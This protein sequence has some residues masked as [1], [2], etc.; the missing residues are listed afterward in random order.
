MN[1]VMN[2]VKPEFPLVITQ[3]EFNRLGKTNKNG[4]IHIVSAISRDT[5]IHNIK[6]EK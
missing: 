6:T 4:L 1:T 5:K 2:T 3:K